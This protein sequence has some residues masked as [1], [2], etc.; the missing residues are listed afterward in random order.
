MCAFRLLAE[1]GV[2]LL[3]V[4][5]S[6]EAFSNFLRKSRE[7]VVL[8]ARWRDKERSSLTAKGFQAI[9]YDYII[10]GAGSAGS[11]IA[12][13]ISQDPDLSVLVV[14][15]GGS[16]R[17]LFIR[18]PAAFSIPMNTRRFA[19]QFHTEPEPAMDNRRLHG[20]RGKVIGGSSSI[21]GMVHVSG[22]RA[23]F[24]EWQA[25]GAEGW[26]YEDCLPYF[27]RSE[28]WIGGGDDYRG[29]SGPLTVSVGE[30]DN[31]LYKAFVDAGVEA[32]YPYTPDYN[33]EH[34]EG[35]STMQMTVRD[36]IRSSTGNAAFKSQTH[37]R[38]DRASRFARG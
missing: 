10:V 4:D 37:C 34:Q 18:M 28:T 19:W 1:V 2:S 27:R 8:A 23:D 12:H 26:G 30:G 25:L 9:E 13:R 38:C 5:Q 17:S 14:E 20:P 35:F 3:V 6:A 7:I 33:G 11:V 36:G 16:D 21:N 29:D 31:P 22:H 24:D 15:A 32:G